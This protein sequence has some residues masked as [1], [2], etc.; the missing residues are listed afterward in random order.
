VRDSLGTANLAP[1]LSEERDSTVAF[2]PRRM[3]ASVEPDDPHF[4]PGLLE[5]RDDATCRV[6]VVAPVEHEHGGAN[7]PKRPFERAGP[8]EP[9]G[10]PPDREEHAG[11]EPGFCGRIR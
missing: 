9:V 3:A 1:K 4:E 8:S 7:A 10:L 6:R 11:F 2:P 5:G